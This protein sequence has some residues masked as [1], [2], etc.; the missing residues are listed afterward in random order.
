MN[1]ASQSQSGSVLASLRDLVPAGPLNFTYAKRITELQANRL[2]D[3]LGVTTAELSEE[4]IRS[5]PKI[6]VI[7]VM[8]LPASGATQWSHG[9]W[10]IAVNGSEPW[11]RQRF[12]VGHELW[13]VINH[14]TV[15][16]FCPDERTRGRYSERLADYFSGCLHM[17]REQI[18]PLLSE[19]YGV[20]DLA[21][22][23]GISTAAVAVRLSQVGTSGRCAGPWSPRKGVAA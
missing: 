18:R 15:E 10:V 2:R 23:F 21:D 20:G 17:P 22:L 7:E 16:R 8:D 1:Y 4:A 13:H 14:Q 3:L 6:K 9:S 5:L 19:G 12:S 11:Q